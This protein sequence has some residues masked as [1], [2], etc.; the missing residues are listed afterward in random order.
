[1]K[2]QKFSELVEFWKNQSNS[3]FSKIQ[4]V[5]EG[6]MFIEDGLFIPISNE[7]HTTVSN[8]M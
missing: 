5:Q 6:F 8:Y 3:K 4:D 1:M 7:K 2:K